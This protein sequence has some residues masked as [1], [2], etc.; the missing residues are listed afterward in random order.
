MKSKA[1][2]YL[3]E[4]ATKAIT[5]S[6][7]EDAIDFLQ[8][9]LTLLDGLPVTQEA[10]ATGLKLRLRLGPILR[11]RYGDW[12]REVE[13]CYTQAL[14]LCNRLGD[15]ASRIAIVH[16]LWACHD[17]RGEYDHASLWSG[18]LLELTS[19]GDAALRLKAQNAAW[20]TA[21]ASGRQAQLPPGLAQADGPDRRRERLTRSMHDSED[22]AWHAMDAVRNWLLGCYD[23]AREG[24]VRGVSS[25]RQTGSSSMA[26]L[27]NYVAA[28]V[29]Y[30]RGER[31]GAMLHAR[32]ASSLG[33]VYGVMNWPEHAAIVVARLLAEEGRLDEAARLAEDSLPRA[34]CAGWPWM[35]SLSF[36]LVADIQGRRGEPAKG[37]DM[38]RS[39]GPE[40]YDGLYGA[41]LHRLYA[42][43]LLAATPDAVSEAEARLRQA[44]ELSR[45]RGLKALELRASMSLAQLITPRDR[46]AARALLSLV[47][48]FSEGSEVVDLRTAR[49]LRDW[50]R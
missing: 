26:A 46:R 41:E 16:G 10:L 34:L 28:V 19:D 20:S 21:I 3:N 49:A 50:L 2:A 39:L 13:A 43:L 29:H 31:G 45:A 30:H 9:A 7:Y 38:L 1:L 6:A 8:K 25:A 14:D 11:E 44:V 24:V 37:L 22:L 32:V 12:S 18:Q 27:A 15:G 47:D 36:G 4:A 33:R 35:A 17:S 48:E 40:R 23:Q 5:R 42:G